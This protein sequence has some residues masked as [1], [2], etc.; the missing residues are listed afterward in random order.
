MNAKNSNSKNHKAFLISGMHRSGTSLTASLLQKAGI[1]IGKKLVGPEYGNIKGHFENIDFVK[2]HQEILRSQNID[3]LGSN[4]LDEQEIVIGEKEKKRGRQLIKKHQKG[5]DLWGWKDP[6]TTLFLD[7]WLELLPYANF[8]FIFRSPW[9]VVDSLYR[10]STDEN[11]VE[12][13][14]VAVKMWQLYN[15]RILKFNQNLPDRCL[16]ANVDKVGKNPEGFIKAIN[17]KFNLNLTAPSEENFD[18]SLL[19]K[20]IENTHRPWLI[21]KNYPQTLEIYRQ[22]KAAA[23]EIEPA[24]DGEEKISAPTSENWAFRD[25]FDVRSLE[26]QAQILELE[27]LQLHKDVEDWH[28]LF[29]EAQE[30]AIALEAALGETE[31]KLDGKELKLQESSE[32][33][34]GLEAELGEAQTQLDGT[35]V[36]LLESQTKVATLERKLGQTQ[37]QLD[38]T[39]V[40]LIDSQ[41]KVLGLETDLGQTQARLEGS[42]TRFQESLTKLVGLETKLGQTEVQ[43]E[44]TKTK[45]HQSQKL[46]LGLETELGHAQIQ[47][48]TTQLKLEESQKKIQ[49]LEKELGD[50]QLRLD[51]SQAQIKESQ[52]KIGELE[53]ELGETQQR[54]DGSQAQIKESQA[55]IGELE[56][57]LGQTQQRLDGSQGQIKESQ[58]K[59]G[60]LEGELGETQLRLDGSQNQLKQSQSKIG[61]LEGELGQTQQ[62]LNGT[63]VKLDESQGKIQV[64][65][66]ELGQTQQ[67][68]QGTQAQLGQTQ[69]EL[70]QTQTALGQTQ[71][72]LS[73]TQTLLGETQTVLVQTEVTLGQT[74]AE[75]IAQR[76]ETQEL[77]EEILA[78]RSSK[79]WKLREK[80]FNFKRRLRGL[81][82]CIRKASPTRFVF[83]LDTPTSWEISSP[84]LEVVGWCFAQGANL[85]NNNNGNLEVDAIRARI[86]DRTFDGSYGI[87]RLDVAQKHDHTPAAQNSG[88][89]IQLELPPGRHQLVL[90]AKDRKDKWHSIASYPII[91]STVQANFDAPATFEQREGMVL[92][93]GWCCHP[94]KKISK[95]TLRCGDVS[96]DCAYGLRR[97][98]VAEAFPQWVG[99]LDSGFEATVELPPGEWPLILEA[100]LDTG[101]IVGFQ[102]QNSLKVRRYGVLDRAKDK[103]LELL[104][105]GAAVRKR[106]A[107]RKQRLGRIVPLP[108][109][110]PRVARRVI[111]MYREQ[112]SFGELSPPAGFLMPV[113][114]EPY[115]AWL[116]VNKWGDR[117]FDRLTSRLEGAAADSL[118]KISVVMPVY[119]PPVEF[120]REAIASVTNQVYQNW[121]LCIADDCSTDPEIRQ[122]LSELAA[123]DPAD[124]DRRTGVSPVPAESDDRRTGVS[125]VPADPRIKIKFREENGNISAA[126]NTAASLATGDFI[127]FLDN[128]DE[129]TPDA[130][131]EVAL[132]LAEHPETDFLYSDDD[133]IDT[134]GDRF[135]PQFKPEWSPELLLSFM[136]MG[137]LCAVRREIFEKVGGLRVGYEG[138][139]DYDFALRATEV[140]RKVAHLPLILYHWRTAP[141]STAVS[142]GEKPASFAA[143]RQAVQD[144]LDRRG[145][146]GKVDRPDW[147]IAENLGIFAPEFPQTG[148]SV[149]IIIPTKNQLHFIKGCLESLEKTSYQNYRVFV[150]DNESDDPKTL[151]Y[152]EGVGGS[153]PAPLEKGGERKVGKA[154]EVRV[155]KIPNEGGKFNFAAINNRAVEQAETDYILFLNN[156]TEIITENWLSQMVGYAQL[157]GVGAVGAKLIYPDGRIQHAGIIHGLHHGLAGH[158]FKLMPSEN[159]GYLS[160]AAVGRNYS[161]VTAACMLTH[162]ELFLEMGGFDEEKFAVAYNDADYGYRLL[163]KG[164]RSVYCPE[165]ELIHR[166]G[167]SRGFVDNPREEAIFRRR[168]A[169]MVD[170]FY[171]PHFS[172]ANELFEVQ[173][174]RYFL[175]PPTPLGK[176]EDRRTGILPVDDA[177][178]ETRFF[179]KT[180][181]LGGRKITLLMC[182][183]SL[184]FTG[185]PLHQY[186]IAVQLA[187]EGIVKPIIF[188]PT[189]GPLR[190]VYEEK[191]IEVI[192]LDNPLEHIYQR[193]DYDAALESFAK[194]IEGLNADVIY[195]NTLENFFLID[196]AQMLNIPSVWN[197]HESEPW[198]TYFNRFGPEIATRALECFRYPYRIIFVAD[199]T[200]DKYLPLNSHHNFTAIHNG[201]D[202]EL[203]KSSAKKWSPE[204][205][206]A[207]LGVNSDEIVLLILGTVCERKGQEDLVKAI[208]Y[209]GA[210]WVGK[211]K[212]FI[213]GDRPSLYSS[214]LSALVAGLPEELKGRIEI[215][216]ETPDTAKYYQAADI[217]VCTSR[218]ESY[219]RVILEAMAYNLP[220]VT[221]P[222]FGIVEQ[223]KPGINGLF[224]TPNQPEELASQLMILLEDEE[225]RLRLGDNAKYVLDA[226]NTF[227]EMTAAYSQIFCEAY[228]SRS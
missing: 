170:K 100:T 75:L 4:L 51:G 45:L 96:I 12:S 183:N 52:A 37:A 84:Q 206:R 62:R 180:G 120:L 54:L 164:Y 59:I 188:S 169:E 111:E 5:K 9:E 49:G 181:F 165:A 216:P 158:A 154:G 69:A 90:E 128:D 197:V 89:Q 199:A 177:E 20:N 15:R 176:E 102:C 212:C 31:L 78:M 18:E 70:T 136:Y 2:Y 126:T 163:E 220:I 157:P 200:R 131:A 186:E 123:D 162:R 153:P 187:S 214:Q 156:D 209:I 86:A 178:Q 57:E 6:R 185:A 92:F 161:A 219:P 85:F 8:I 122:I 55:K 71:S 95:L 80:W 141:G 130:L 201:L 39:Q 124:D 211:I 26:K 142:G 47:L 117:A 91:V 147:A 77:R 208:P 196:I 193:D 143:G 17:D 228:L 104:Q 16:I 210:E 99:S 83:S 167:T 82:Y 63:Q 38:G 145:V 113:S 173:P 202:L 72:A 195:A 175:S 189:E 66:T 116:E 119:N 217:F 150:I 172:L 118:P 87:E 105:L 43:L 132:Y 184:D 1:N 7:L 56:G 225:L 44:G 101:E 23:I 213:V 127:L 159:R 53:G 152:L 110:L 151:E 107:E 166:E 129:L 50:T 33:L 139:Q 149:T 121:E 40:K 103:R 61:E 135:D 74:Q 194:E 227:E 204:E 36:K 29:E 138:S 155:L 46:L 68:L 226:L 24:D 215:V 21:E 190:K 94:E 30:R 221:T 10:R 88:F 224:Y 48:N 125:P 93:A 41:K 65:E 148:P 144:A 13:P 168:Y 223:V 22:L 198:Q 191:N 133:K 108:W 34:E 112:K 114:V 3:D 179:G 60:E 81:R 67:Q 203:L 109:E 160:Q 207:A 98:D 192:V 182:S 25:W 73:Q 222:V 76:Q 137:H 174:R 35:K 32:K 42:E 218:I 11:L 106:A 27:A 58:A 97:K 14:E 205:A 115:E 134:E 79:F 171:S 64:L 19:I 28:K 140:S 146:S